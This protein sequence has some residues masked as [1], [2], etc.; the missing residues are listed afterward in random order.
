MGPPAI[1][2]VPAPPMRYPI[3]AYA[4]WIAPLDRITSESAPA[5]QINA[6]ELTCPPVTQS[7]EFVV[8]PS[9]IGNDAVK[10]PPATVTVPTLPLPIRSRV[11][12]KEPL[13]IVSSPSH[14]LP[15]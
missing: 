12:W 6:P 8:A 4:V 13:E 15:T 3:C 1:V 5:P 14:Q 10:V 11:V 2:N 9:S 7:V